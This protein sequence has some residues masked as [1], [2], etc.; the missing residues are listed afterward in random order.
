M[1]IGAGDPTTVRRRYPRWYAVLAVLWLLGG[2]LLL[3]AAPDGIDPQI[4]IVPD[5][6]CAGGSVIVEVLDMPPDGKW[7]V[8]V[9]YSRGGAD[10][11]HEVED[12]DSTATQSNV[13][14]Q[15]AGGSMTV[16]VGMAGESVSQTFPVRLCP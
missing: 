5:P 7:T 8:T 4:V 9:R 2:P 12:S 15:A 1:R 16:T 10:P 3:G 6:P 11:A 14:A 13:P